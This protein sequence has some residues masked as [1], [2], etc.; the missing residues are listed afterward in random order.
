LGEKDMKIIAEI[1]CNHKGNLEIAK[2]MSKIAIIECGINIVKF[3]KRTPKELLTEEEYNKPHPNIENSYGKTYGEHREFLEFNILQHKEL[4]NYI[5]KIGGV[6]SCSV[7]D[8][9]S[10]RE[11]VSLNPKMIKIPSACNTDFLLL[12]YIAKH[13]E[14]EIHLSLGMTKVSEEVEIIKF[15]EKHNRLKDIVLYSCV[16]NYPVTYNELCLLDVILKK[17]NY[18]KRVKAIGFSGH[19][20][21]IKADIVAM[22][23]GAEYIERHFTLDKNW[24]GT[25]HK[26][27][28]IPEEIKLL[29]DNLEEIEK[30]MKYKDKDIL[31]CEIK[32]REK[33]KRIVK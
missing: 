21:D 14:G 13:F 23:L 10:A 5:E 30:A 9:T 32:Q 7:W 20:T 15:F 17:R 12:D 25:D 27:S 26:A 6:Y 28:L 19:H 3:Q 18:K 11:I 22:T 33:L 2:E 29:R 31:D 24:K 4:K 1:G 16:S 8:I